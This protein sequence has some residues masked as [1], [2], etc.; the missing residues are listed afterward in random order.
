MIQSNQKTS[1]LVPYQLPKFI[2]ED[3]SYANF[4]LF[5][6]AY[7]EWLEQEG[8]VLDSTKSIMSNLDVDTTSEQFLQYFLNDFNFT[9]NHDLS[10]SGASENNKVRYYLSGGYNRQNSPLTLADD[11]FD[12]LS[13]LP[14]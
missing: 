7:Y 4:I 10:V 14:L 5:L 11:Y 9:H 13:R 1:L 6:Q 12:W 8:N 2:S 3:P